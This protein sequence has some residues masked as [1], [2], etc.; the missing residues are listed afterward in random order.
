MR[1]KIKLI[2]KILKAIKS[3]CFVVFHKICYQERINMHYLNSIKGKCKISLQKNSKFYVGDFLMIDSPF[4]VKCGENAILKIGNHCFFNHNV[5]ITSNKSIK[6]GNECF[7]ANNIV[8]VDHDH[9][10]TEKFN[11]GTQFK[12]KSIEIGNNVWIGANVTILKGTKIGDGSV[13]AA[14]AVVNRNVPSHEIW[15]RYQQK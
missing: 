2:F 5:S 4:Y 11:Y 3:I 7:F 13:I 8:V 1:G 14:G 15:G 12:T 10:I 6:I 9:L